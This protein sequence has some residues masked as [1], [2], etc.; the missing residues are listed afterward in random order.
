ML[1]ETKLEQI[2]ARGYVARLVRDLRNVS[3]GIG[4]VMIATVDDDASA[5]IVLNVLNVP[6]LD[7]DEPEPVG[8]RRVR[9]RVPRWAALPSELRNELRAIFEK[10]VTEA[11]DKIE[12]SLEKGVI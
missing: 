7:D 2:E 10:A 1:N 6:T 8:R 4:S 12:A 9:R 3:D 11:A 5:E